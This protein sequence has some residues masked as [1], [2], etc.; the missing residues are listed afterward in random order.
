M[1]YY[2]IYNKLKQPTTDSIVT[3][4]NCVTNKPLATTSLGK[5]YTLEQGF[6]YNVHLTHL[7]I[8]DSLL[9]RRYTS[10]LKLQSQYSLVKH[11]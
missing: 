4:F 1:H 2:E 11:V 3:V 9:S 10:V 6:Q 5:I 8:L 7:I